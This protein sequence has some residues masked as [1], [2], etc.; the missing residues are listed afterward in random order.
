MRDAPYIEKPTIFHGWLCS[1]AFVINS[2]VPRSASIAPTKWLAVLNTWCR[3][4]WEGEKRVTTQAQS[5]QL[6][7]DAERDKRQVKGVRAGAVK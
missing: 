2:A 3:R 7:G 6:G 1:L 5:K 4:A